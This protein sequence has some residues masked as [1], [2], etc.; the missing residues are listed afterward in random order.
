MKEYEIEDFNIITQNMEEK[1]I[2]V[3]T[4][5]NIILTEK[6]DIGNIRLIECSENEAVVYSQEHTLELSKE[7]I[8][9]LV[10][11][12]V[13]QVE[14]DTGTVYSHFKALEMEFK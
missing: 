7:D 1:A 13:S 11:E 2:R 14:F 4:L 6:F 12:L 3:P 5:L 9:E 8:K 10:F